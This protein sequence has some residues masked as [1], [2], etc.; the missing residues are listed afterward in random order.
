MRL[1]LAMPCISL[2]I[3]CVSKALELPDDIA[4][5]AQPGMPPDGSATLKLPG[6]TIRLT[7]GGSRREARV[8]ILP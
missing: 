2:S 5:F 6:R 8:E 1:L 4:P 7:Q 3:P